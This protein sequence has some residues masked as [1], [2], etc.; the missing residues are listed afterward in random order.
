MGRVSKVADVDDPHSH[1]G[2]GDGAGQLSPKL[3][4]LLLQRR[5]LWLHSCH[6]APDLPQLRVQACGHCDPHCLAGCDISALAEGGK[7][8]GR[9]STVGP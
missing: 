7:R 9:L 3:V 2:H 4:Q 6:L 5:P 8:D 1:A